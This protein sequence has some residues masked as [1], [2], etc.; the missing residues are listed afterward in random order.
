ML[1]ETGFDASKLVS[2]QNALSINCND[3]VVKLYVASR[4]RQRL[5]PFVDTS[6]ATSYSMFL[7]TMHLKH[8]VVG[9]FSRTSG[10]TCSASEH[11]PLPAHCNTFR[12]GTLHRLVMAGFGWFGR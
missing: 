6:I 7:E 3:R 1:E 10:L 5:L 2:E 8:S 12:T 4:C 9:K 11:A